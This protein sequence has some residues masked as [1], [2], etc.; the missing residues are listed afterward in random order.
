MNIWNK[1]VKRVSSEGDEEVPKFFHLTDETNGQMPFNT[2][3]VKIR[4]YKD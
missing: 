1:L 4:A 3:T 2:A